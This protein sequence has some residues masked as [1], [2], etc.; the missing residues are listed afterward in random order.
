MTT[1]SNYSLRLQSSHFSRKVECFTH[2]KLLPRT[3][4]QSQS[5]RFFDDPQQGWYWSAE[6]R[7]WIAI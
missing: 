1:T 5:R 3:G 7:G 4:S 2:R 6:S